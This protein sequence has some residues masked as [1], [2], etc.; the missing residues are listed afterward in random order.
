MDDQ[1]QASR[2]PASFLVRAWRRLK[3]FAA[4]DPVRFAV[5]FVFL[6]ICLGQGGWFLWDFYQQRR[7]ADAVLAL[8]H[9]TPAQMNQ[10][11]ETERV[12]SV[13]SHALNTGSLISPKVTRYSEARLADGSRFIMES[14]TLAQEPLQKALFERALRSPI[15]FSEGLNH[16]QGLNRLLDFLS[17]LLYVGSFVALFMIVQRAATDLL[18]GKNFRLGGHDE[19]ISFD[20]IIGYEEVKRELREVLDQLSSAKKYASQGV[21]APRGILLTGAPGVGKTMFAKALANLHNAKFL[22]ATGADFVELYVGTGARRARALFK[23]ARA[24]SPAVIFIDEID[25][26]GARDQ[27]GMD[28]E[29]LSTINQMLSE[30]D[31]MIENGQ[32][33]VIGA[34]NHPEKLD[35]ALLR[36][37]RF[38]K[39]IHIP[40]PDLPTREGILR[41]HLSDSGMDPALDLRAFA[42]RS[43]GMSGAELKNWAAEAK[44]LALR[45]SSGDSAR[46]SASHLERAQEILLLGV[47]ERE[48]SSKELERVAFHELGHALAAH[49]L[50]PHLEVAKVSVGG[51]GLALGFTMQIPI[52]EKSLHTQSEMLAQIATLLAGRAAEQVMLGDVSNGSADDL[53]K[54]S[55]LALRMASSFGMGPSSGLLVS[56][57]S[58]STG[59]L[60]QAALDDARRILDDQFQVAL[61]LIESESDWMRQS[62]K[63]LLERGSLG[64]EEL[65]SD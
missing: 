16:Q 34:T 6:S 29:R 21:K 33:L 31:G 48:A 53:E 39:K 32:V 5:L 3:R 57:P 64:R 13:V 51:R 8:P 54:A 55:A 36:P 20:D 65:F 17:F 47:S 38:D 24:D 14:S 50:C 49:R 1:T 10:A 44:N 52:E 41:K 25:A 7:E 22:Y 27:W 19:Q 62:S 46:V 63:L 40:N 58:P 56:K 4:I 61:D 42:L 2:R 15:E 43:Q 9:W 12:R 37:G 11:L 35:P 59:S 45:E 23:E 60:P 26:L 30:M 28:S 18:V